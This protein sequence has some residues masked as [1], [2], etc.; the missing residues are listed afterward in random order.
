MS[1]TKQV[2]DWRI[3]NI[4]ITINIATEETID[5]LESKLDFKQRCLYF[6]HWTFV[7][8]LNYNLFYFTKSLLKRQKNC[9]CL[10][11]F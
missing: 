10:N 1:S 3:V 4:I 9:V 6:L 11:F 8:F 7:P 2:F 5:H